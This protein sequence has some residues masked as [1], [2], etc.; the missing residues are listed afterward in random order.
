VIDEGGVVVATGD[1]ALRLITVQR[2]GKPRV[3]AV[4]IAHG[5]GWA[6]GR[7]LATPQPRNPE[8]KQSRNTETP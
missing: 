8:A 1:S 3:A 7:N 2:P 4:E 5:A 6:V